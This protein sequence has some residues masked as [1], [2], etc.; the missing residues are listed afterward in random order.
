[1]ALLLHFCDFFKD[2][3]RGWLKRFLSNYI[4][5]LYYLDQVSISFSS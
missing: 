5:F 2:F 3:V 1:M 4:R